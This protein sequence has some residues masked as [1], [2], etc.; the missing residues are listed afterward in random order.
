PRS[1]S[2]RRACASAPKTTVPSI[3]SRSSPVGEQLHALLGPGERAASRRGADRGAA[4]GAVR[5][6]ALRRPVVREVPAA[7][8]VRL[9]PDEHAVPDRLRVRPTVLWA[10]IADRHRA[11]RFCRTFRAEPRL[12]PGLETSVRRLMLVDEDARPRVAAQVLQL[13]VVREDDDV[14][15]AVAPAVP[16]RREE[17][18]AVPAIRRQDG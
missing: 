11:S 9:E 15:A 10:E 8:L 5:A 3:T 2:G 14:E 13:D 17:D 7:E 16:H 1:G 12:T 6:L 4:A 18:A